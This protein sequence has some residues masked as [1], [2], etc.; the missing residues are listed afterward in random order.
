MKHTTDDIRQARA[1][2]WEYHYNMRQ[3]ARTLAQGDLHVLQYATSQL[4]G[5]P[6]LTPFGNSAFDHRTRQA[7][8]YIAPH[9]LDANLLCHWY[10]S[11]LGWKDFVEQFNSMPEPV[12]MV[13]NAEI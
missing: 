8:A 7:Y 9:N 1:E 2:A 6:Q 11:E 13:W 12:E 10:L 4:C 5:I 3:K